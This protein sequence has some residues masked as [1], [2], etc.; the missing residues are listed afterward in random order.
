MFFSIARCAICAFSCKNMY[1]PANIVKYISLQALNTLIKISDGSLDDIVLPNVSDELSQID[2]K[3]EFLEDS[4]S[5]N[6]HIEIGENDIKE[7]MI[8]NSHH[9]AKHP[10][11]KDK[12]YKCSI[13]DAKFETLSERK[14]HSASNHKEEKPYKCPT[15]ESQFSSKHILKRHILDVHENNKPFMCHS[16]PSAFIRDAQLKLH[17]ESVH[18]KLKPHKCDKCT[19]CF[20]RPFGLKQHIL[21]VHEG[22]I[23]EKKKFCCEECGDTLS[24]AALLKRHIKVKHFLENKSIDETNINE[25]RKDP[26]VAAMIDNKEYKGYVCKLCYKKVLFGKSA[27]IKK[28]H[29][30]NDIECPKCDK[31]FNT[32]VSAMGHILN[33]HEKKPCTI[34]GEVFG[35]TTMIRHI[36]QAHSA[37]EEKKFKCPTCGKGFVVNNALQDHIN[38]H[39]GEKPHV[40]KVCGKGFASYG[41]LRTHE[42]GRGEYSSEC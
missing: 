36:Q 15:C 17:I 25:F 23:P 3:E 6:N 26:E 16:C 7:E 33:V 8:I 4:E 42:R 27:H 13:C 37:N 5:P 34:C 22:K 19:Q 30:G 21:I 12:K 18:L 20:S 24:S 14:S 11:T 9:K 41:T 38:I 1:F 35:Y 29:T 2:V 39:T 10:K 40:C 31:T 32:Y 28:Y